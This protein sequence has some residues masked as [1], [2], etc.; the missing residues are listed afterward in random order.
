LAKKYHISLPEK[1][2]APRIAPVYVNAKAQVLL[3][4]I[5]S[6]YLPF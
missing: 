5:S 3:I 2:P 1:K 6:P 4:P